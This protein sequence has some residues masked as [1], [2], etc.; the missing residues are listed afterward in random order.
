MS[1]VTI[2]FISIMALHPLLFDR[3]VIIY[4]KSLQIRHTE[5]KR[6]WLKYVLDNMKDHSSLLNSDMYVC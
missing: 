1:E 2:Y 4:C 6:N 3:H 5:N